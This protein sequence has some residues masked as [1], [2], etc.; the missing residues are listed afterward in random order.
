MTEKM[1]AKSDKM[2]MR[3]LH[4]QVEPRPRRS[5]NP[6]AVQITQLRGTKLDLVTDHPASADPWKTT[7]LAEMKQLVVG[8]PGRNGH[9][10]DCR[11]RLVGHPGP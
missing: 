3:E 2:F 5:A 8:K 7:R 4:G 9:V 10:M 6:H 1:I 11:G